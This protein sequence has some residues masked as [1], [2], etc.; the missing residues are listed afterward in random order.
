M[1]NTTETTPTGSTHV[2]Y[3]YQ[4]SAIMN[5]GIGITQN[6][7]G[8]DGTGKF[9]GTG[10]KVQGIC[11]TGWHIPSHY[12]WTYM[13]KQ[14][15]S[16]PGAFLYN[17]SPEAWLGTDEGTNLK[18][19]DANRLPSSTY[20]TNGTDAKGFAGVLAGYRYSDGSFSN[21]GVNA[22]LWSSSQYDSSSAWYRYLLYNMPSVYRGTRDKAGGCSAR[23]LK[24]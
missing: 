13:E 8:V 7:D 6:T 3:A 9:N 1:V 15:G 14:A 17:Y 16:N 24:D 20:N 4:W 2:G 11:P 12:E 5:G 21:R 10:P 18:T 23:C 19:T 22:Y